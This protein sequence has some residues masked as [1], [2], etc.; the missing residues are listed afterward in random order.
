[1]AFTLCSSQH[2]QI[3]SSTFVLKIFFSKARQH[4]VAVVSYRSLGDILHNRFTERR[5][6][7]ALNIPQL[8]AL[9]HVRLRR[10][11][12][13]RGVGTPH[14]KISI[15]EAAFAIVEHVKCLRLV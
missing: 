6:V 1:M 4:L 3:W 9:I 2:P 8:F 5:T 14:I 15:L 11:D 10:Y 12:A 13:V 7:L